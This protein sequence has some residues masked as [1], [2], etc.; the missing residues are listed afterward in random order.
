MSWGWYTP[1]KNLT[2]K[3]HPNVG[4]F[5]MQIRELH[6]YSP[7]PFILSFLIL[8]Y[9]KTPNFCEYLIK[10]AITFLIIV[11]FSKF[12]NWLAAYDLYFAE[13]QVSSTPKLPKLL[14]S[15]NFSLA[16]I[17][18]FTI[19]WICMSELTYCY[20][21][22]SC[23]NM[24]YKETMHKFTQSRQKTKWSWESWI[25]HWISAIDGLC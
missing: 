8:K 2:V 9:C 4:V 21:I 19:M 13:I 18:C 1:Q 16:K 3:V 10:M 12:K 5:E 6:F 24:Y 23:V 7:T 22:S 15:R 20:F 25:L 17:K 11:R 14:N